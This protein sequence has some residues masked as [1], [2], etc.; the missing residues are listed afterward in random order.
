M[1]ALSDEACGKLL[2]VA[3][4]DA[5]LRLKTDRQ[6]ADL[7]MSLVWAEIPWTDVR[8]AVVSA[9]IDRLRGDEEVG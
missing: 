2:E 3:K 7:L 8:S 1:P 6:I 4:V 5:E 9:A